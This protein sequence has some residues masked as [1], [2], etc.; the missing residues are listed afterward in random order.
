MTPTLAWLL[1]TTAA[2]LGAFLYAIRA[3]LF[4]RFSH[5]F[6]VTLMVALVG[7]GLLTA[8]LQGVIDSQLS[9]LLVF[10]GLANGMSATGG[11]VQAQI[12]D[13]VG[14][15]VNVLSR[16][17]QQISLDDARRNPAGLRHEFANLKTFHQLLMQL[18]VVD[19]EG[20]PVASLFPMQQETPLAKDALDDL[21]Q[22]SFYISDPWMSR[23]FRRWFITLAVPIWNDQHR[24][25]GALISN[26]DLQD[27]LRTI[28]VP[29][30]FGKS[31]F[32]ILTDSRGKV[33]A[34]PDLAH[35]GED[36]SSYAA[37]QHG[38][39]GQ[40][41][42]LTGAD[43]NGKQWVFVYRPIESPATQGNHS[44]TLLIQTSPAEALA[45]IRTLR[46]EFMIG[47]GVFL[48]FSMLLALEV[49]LSTVKPL[50]RLLQ[51]IRAVREGHLDQ[52]VPIRGRDEV[53]QL[54]EALNEM[55]D[56]LRQRE[57]IERTLDEERAQ[58]ARIESELQIARQTQLGLL[59]HT[60]NLPQH[61]PEVDIHASIEP[62]REV[63]GDFYDV[64]Y[65]EDGRVG[66][67]I[68][69]VSGKGVP[70][71]LHMAIT[72]SLI[73]AT[74]RHGTLSPNEVLERVNQ[75]LARNNEQMVFITV[76]LAILDP[77]TGILTY[78]N[79]GHNPPL[80]LREGGRVELV[81][82]RGVALG[83]D[84]D[85]TYVQWTT[86]MMPHDSLL[87]YTDGVTEAFN[88]QE[89]MF[90]ETGLKTAMADMRGRSSRDVV[91]QIVEAVRTFADGAPQSDDLTLMAV[92]YC[93]TG[94]AAA[95]TGEQSA[96]AMQ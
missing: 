7:L 32:S 19:V 48:I 16:M 88:P 5:G 71:S 15:I 52:H 4:A 49:S 95:A 50:N 17:S 82:G 56:A 41:G 58:G 1:L 11:V 84:E 87:L 14:N 12:Q 30:H 66:M 94:S 3:G 78:S 24:V 47:M 67:V 77:A 27:M 36:L 40:S 53:N 76:F 55:A 34:Y 46:R 65:L 25:T 64:I 29:A 91:Q 35:V 44:W 23:Y 28:I 54:G 8:G 9:H 37:V 72:K 70:A 83:V 22:G 90:D 45:P 6:L 63:G 33:L 59:P 62:A 75:E 42:W 10:N 61:P 89:E 43:K 96:A 18:A 26:Y 73:E 92:R 2:G 31:G 81:S 51:F 60:F 74:A 79:A 69:D 38:I 80:M 85:A 20:H 21:R 86:P 39:Q 68:G 93:G 13:D 57:E